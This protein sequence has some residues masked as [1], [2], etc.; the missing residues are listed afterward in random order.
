MLWLFYELMVH[1][2]PGDRCLRQ[3]IEHVLGD[4]L[5]GQHGQKREQG[6][7]SYHTE[8]IPEIAAGSH[9]DVLDDVAA[10]DDV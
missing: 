1:V 4:Q 9:F 5:D 2:V 3:I 8:H 10:E 6:A 7:G